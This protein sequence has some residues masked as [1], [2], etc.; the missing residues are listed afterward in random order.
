MSFKFPSVGVEQD[1]RKIYC[2]DKI[3]P[4]YSV[5]EGQGCPE[6]PSLYD[7]EM[8]EINCMVSEIT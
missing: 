3:I 6:G 7:S 1:D 2:I 5:S 8:N 4:P